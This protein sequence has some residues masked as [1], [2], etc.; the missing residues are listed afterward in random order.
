MWTSRRFNPSG[1]SA[2]TD[3]RIVAGASIIGLFLLTSI[4]S[5]VIVDQSDG[6]WA[7]AVSAGFSTCSQCHST[8]EMSSS[9]GTLTRT[10]SW[11]VL[12]AAVGWRWAATCWCCPAQH[13]AADAPAAL[14]E[15]C[16][17]RACPLAADDQRQITRLHPHYLLTATVGSVS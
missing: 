15:P 11:A 10:H 7:K 1:V 14:P 12:Q 5:G 17:G 4:A 13:R 6:R 2:L 16:P 9:S 8:Y 3:R